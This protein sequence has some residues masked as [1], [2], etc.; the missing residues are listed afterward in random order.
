MEQR[1][2][3]EGAEESDDEIDS[4]CGSAAQKK[5]VGSNCIFVFPTSS[6]RR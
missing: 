4:P 3:T 6:T 5:E 2:D 1:H